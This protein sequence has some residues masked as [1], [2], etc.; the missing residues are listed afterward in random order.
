MLA[1]IADGIGG[2][3]GVGLL[4]FGLSLAGEAV[5]CALDL[6]LTLLQS[7]LLAVGL[8]VGCE[9]VAGAWGFVSAFLILAS[10]AGSGGGWCCTLTKVVSHFGSVWVVGCWSCLCGGLISVFLKKREWE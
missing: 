1:S 3:L 2:L 9:L 8:Q 10:T 4:V 6:V 7:R 5:G